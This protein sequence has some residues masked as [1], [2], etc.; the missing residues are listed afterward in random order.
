MYEWLYTGFVLEIVFIEPL[1]IVTTSKAYAVTVLHVLQKSLSDT[2][3]LLS[4]L[5]V[6][7][8]LSGN[9]FQRCR[10]L[11]FRVHGF[12]SSLAVTAAPELT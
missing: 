4:L 3:G 6:H 8:S 12:K 11:N 10:S 7:Q 9:G 5:C 1:Q 2:L